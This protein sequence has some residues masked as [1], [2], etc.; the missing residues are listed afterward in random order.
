MSLLDSETA[1]DEV[2]GGSRIKSEGGSITLA[3]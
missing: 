1:S 3:E 2:V